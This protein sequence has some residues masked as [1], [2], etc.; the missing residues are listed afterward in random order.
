MPT[1]TCPK[2]QSKS[3][4]RSHTRNVI[5]KCLKVFK[6]RA[7][8]CSQC[9]WRG[10]RY[11]KG[12]PQTTTAKYGPLQI[13]MFTIAIALTVMAVIYYLTSE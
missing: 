4:R 10:L 7:Y 2:C 13:L 6:I 1:W 8:R 12:S 5:E 9:D 11:S 3:V